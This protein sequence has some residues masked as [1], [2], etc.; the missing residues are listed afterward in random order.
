MFSLLGVSATISRDVTVTSTRFLHAGQGNVTVAF[1]VFS[2]ILFV[3]YTG[4]ETVLEL[5]VVARWRI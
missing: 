5:R 2:H 3:I 4:N 1:S